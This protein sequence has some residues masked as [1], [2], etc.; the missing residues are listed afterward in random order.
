MA[1]TRQGAAVPPKGSALDDATAGELT[2]Q[3]PKKKRGASES[4]NQ[5]QG[6]AKK[7]KSSSGPSI[8]APEP[9]E[10]QQAVEQQQPVPR[11]TTPDLEFDW[12]RSKLKD[13]RPTPGRERRPR[14]G[15]FDLPAELAARRPSTPE[16]PKGRLNAMQKEAL[17]A[18]K[19]RRDPAATFHDLHK[20][21]DKGPNG[22]PTYDSGGFRLDY[23]KVMDWFKP[24]RYSKSKMV[25]GM[26]R[27]LARGRSLDE[28]MLEAFFEDFEAAKEKIMGRTITVNLVKDTISKDLGI[29]FHKIDHAEIDMWEKKGYEK[30]KV[31]DYMTYSE[32]DKKRDMK[33]LMGSS[34]RA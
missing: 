29:P 10:T 5:R 20:C 17:E 16:K 14:H 28:H 11:L 15:S 32:E 4:R 33:M 22:S 18:E 2:T 25:K 12:D 24:V 21:R 23:N 1:R 19:T 6:P 34:L 3:A 31:E 9:S 7:R 13:P 26:D 30:R 8:D 27:A